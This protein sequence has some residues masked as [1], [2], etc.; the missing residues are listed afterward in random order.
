MSIVSL[1]AASALAAAC[2]PQHETIVALTGP[3]AKDKLIVE[4]LGPD[5][6]DP[7]LFA[8]VFSATGRLLFAHAESG[9]FLLNTESFPGGDGTL[10]GSLAASYEV[11]HDVK[12]GSLPE[13]KK[14]KPKAGMGPYSAYDVRVPQEYYEAIRKENLPVLIKRGGYESGTLYIYDKKWNQFVEIAEYS[15][16]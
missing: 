3:K 7:V 13:W 11:M 12:T 4:A 16:G 5:C 15:A 10:K 8:R 14:G 6:K 9:A 2:V 1:I